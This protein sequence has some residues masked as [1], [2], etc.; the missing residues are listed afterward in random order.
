MTITKLNVAATGR[1]PW[2]SRI[3]DG[4]PCCGYASKPWTF[5]AISKFL[6][7]KLSTILHSYQFFIILKVI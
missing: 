2:M 7:F 1:S 4:P 3:Y 5:M 6:A